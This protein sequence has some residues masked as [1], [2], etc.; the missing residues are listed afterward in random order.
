MEAKKVLFIAHRKV[1]LE[2]QKYSF[3]KIIKDK[4]LKIFESAI[5]KM[6]KD[7]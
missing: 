1:I 3:S 2:N 4:E 7:R 6:V 5:E